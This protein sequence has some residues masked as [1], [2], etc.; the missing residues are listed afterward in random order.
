MEY[1]VI[2]TQDKLGKYGTAANGFVV[3]PSHQFTA[4]VEGYVS[5]GWELF[6]GVS[7]S[8]GKLSQAMI[9]EERGYEG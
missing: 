6:G 8:E 3:V 9:K 1:I 5:M 2:T 4:A 7:V